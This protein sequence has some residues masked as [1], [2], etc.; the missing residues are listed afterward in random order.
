MDERSFIIIDVINIPLSLLL[1]SR[2]DH[3]IG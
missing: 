2:E 1:K 3:L